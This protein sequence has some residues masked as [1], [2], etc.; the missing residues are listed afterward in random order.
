VRVNRL[1]AVL[2]ALL[3][4]S[5]CSDPVTNPM[6]PEQARAQVMDAGREVIATLHADVVRA[7]FFF[8]S[9]SDAG[10]GPYRGRLRVRLWMPNADHGAAV[11]PASIIDPLTAAGWQTDSDFQSHAPTLKR[12]GV[13]AV[14]SVAPQPQGNGHAGIDLFGE[15]RDTHDH[16]ADRSNLPEDVAPTVPDR[17][18]RRGSG[19]PVPWCSSSCR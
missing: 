14:I 15:C 18:R 4:G 7:N 10:Q 17:R 5:G 1:A 16:D 9:C 11:A 12:D 3:A 8:D 6:S 13:D 2:G 19:L